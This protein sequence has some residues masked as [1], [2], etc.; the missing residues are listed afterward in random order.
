MKMASIVLAW[1]YEGALHSS[2][3]L[4]R[5][6]AVSASNCHITSGSRSIANSTAQPG[7]S[8]VLW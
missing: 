3:E 4:P 7:E 1:R 8:G 2:T 5:L 6:A